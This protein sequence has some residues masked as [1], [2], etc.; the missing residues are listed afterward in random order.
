MASL[1]STSEVETAEQA[2][3][4][5]AELLVTPTQERGEAPP[6]YCVNPATGEYLQAASQG[7]VADP[8]P[9]DIDGW[10]VPANAYLDQPPSAG[11][12]QAIIRTPNGW[13]VVE[14]HRGN[15]YRTDTG[16]VEQLTA[17][18]PLPAG[19]TD[20]PR[21]SAAYVWINGVW[22]LDESK[23]AELLNA[24]CQALCTTIDRAADTARAKVVGDPTRA[25]EYQKAAEEAQAFADAG[26]PAD[27]VP[28]TVSAYMLGARTATQAADSI[29]AE[30]AAY[31]EALYFLRETR[32]AA[33]E[34][35][36]ALIAAGEL[37]QAQLHAEQTVGAIE[38]AVAGV[39]NNAE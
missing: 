23:Q 19:L 9:M 21:P 7:Q 6:I 20:Q 1:D 22:V 39:G 28:R 16:A 11:A 2:P 14:D 10:L 4:A 25:L 8:D 15:Y 38:A 12:G 18:G 13:K 33:K 26:Y 5:G 37:A 30:A 35:I 31:N 36:A 32:L 24:S 17:L 3:V 34:A 27:A 29:L